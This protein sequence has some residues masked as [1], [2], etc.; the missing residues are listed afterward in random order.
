MLQFPPFLIPLNES[1]VL[2]LKN[3]CSPRPA[4]TSQKV[5]FVNEF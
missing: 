4:S 3:K 2:R 1:E 5:R